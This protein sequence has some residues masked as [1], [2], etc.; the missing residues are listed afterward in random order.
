MVHIN[1]IQTLNPKLEKLY[2][3]ASVTNAELVILPLFW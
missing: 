1:F 2:S 3:Y